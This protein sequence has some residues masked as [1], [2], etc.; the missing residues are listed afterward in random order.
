VDDERTRVELQAEID[1]PREA[2]FTLFATADGLRS[3]VDE[4]ELEPRVGG[5]VRLQLH[6][7]AGIGTIVSLA[8]PQHMS[9]TWD[10]EGEPIGTRT[11]VAFDAIEHGHA[12]HLT[13]RHVGLRGRRTLEVHAELWSYWFERLRLAADALAR[14]HPR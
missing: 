9:F 5:S 2:V 10:W 1:A 14:T 13:L 8:P 6:D 7:A 4:A 11:V 12:T 3:W